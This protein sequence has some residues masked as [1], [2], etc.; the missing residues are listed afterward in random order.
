M[1]YRNKTFISF[2]SEDIKSYR[3]MQAWKENENIDFNFFDA[4]DLNTALDTSTP[5]TI[6]RRL[7]ERLANAKQ[8][9]LLVGDETKKKAAKSTSFISY[10]VDVISGLDIP[11]IIVNLNQSRVSENNRIPTKLTGDIY[12]I[13]TS[14][15]PKIIKYA[16]DNFP[17]QYEKNKKD[18]SEKRKKG[19]YYYKDFVYENL[20][21]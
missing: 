20:G 12:T 6:K 10:E 16:L 19:P 13:S 7:R 2:A 18:S 21:L 5:E 17:E 9:I 15:Q 14:F 4:H 3:L 1:A 11:V 8:V